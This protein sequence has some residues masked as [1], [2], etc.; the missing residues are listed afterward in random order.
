MTPSKVGIRRPNP[1]YVNLHVALSSSIPLVPRTI[2]TA[3]KHPGWLATMHEELA[4]LHKNQTWNLVPKDLAM[5]IV[6]C[7]WVYK[8]KLQP[9]R[10]V[11][12]LKARLVAKG[13]HQVDGLDFHETFSPVIKPASI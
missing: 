5:N 11:E 4:A 13:F 7:K 12:R 3:Q 8:V 9:D 6:G 10:S 2:I 1:K